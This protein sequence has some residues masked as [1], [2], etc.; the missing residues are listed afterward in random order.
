MVVNFIPCAFSVPEWV[1]RVSHTLPIGAHVKSHASQAEFNALKVGLELFDSLD[2]QQTEFAPRSEY[3]DRSGQKHPG[4]LDML[5][6]K[7]GRT[8]HWPTHLAS[9]L[10]DELRS[11]EV[12]IVERGDWEEIL[13]SVPI[14]TEYQCIS[15]LRCCYKRAH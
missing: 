1:V 4:L 3:S 8:P 10:C 12:M 14:H 6:P 13:C 11:M 9:M 15:Y 5:E 7:Q 2:E